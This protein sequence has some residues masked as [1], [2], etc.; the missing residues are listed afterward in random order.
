MSTNAY[1]NW[2]RGHAKVV[3][4]RELMDPTAR[5]WADSELEFWIDQWQNELQQDYELV[6]G[7]ATI[8]TALNTITL[9]TIVPPMS[10][11]DEQIS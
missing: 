9:G 8:T 7:T 4:R 2:D 1:Q 10:R 11:L 3:I 6:W 5:W